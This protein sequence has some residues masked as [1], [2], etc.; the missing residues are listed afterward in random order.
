MWTYGFVHLLRVYVLHKR[1]NPVEKVRAVLR[2]FA[3][4][5]QWAE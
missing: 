3:K 5:V 4:H 2:D 1:R